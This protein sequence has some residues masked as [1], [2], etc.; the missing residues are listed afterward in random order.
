MLIATAESE[1]AFKDM[2]SLPY[3]A[4]A[5]L[6]GIVSLGRVVKN[7]LRHLRQRVM[8]D[9]QRA[10]CVV[11]VR[12][13]PDLTQDAMQVFLLRRAKNAGFMASFHAF[14]GG[15]IEACDSLFDG[16]GLALPYDLKSDAKSAAMRELFEE[17]DVFFTD[18]LDDKARQRLRQNPDLWPQIANKALASAAKKPEIWPMGRWITPPF[19]PRRFDATYILMRMPKGEIARVATAEHE[20]GY[21]L[22]PKQALQAHADGELLLAYPVLE[23]L[24]ILEHAQGDLAQASALAC[25]RTQNPPTRLGGE[26]AA[27]IHCLPVKTPTLPPATHTNTYILGEDRHVIIDPA[28][29][30]P[31]EQD[32][33][34]AYLEAQKSQ[35]AH[36]QAI[37]LTH[38]HPDHLGAVERVQKL[39]DL[40][41]W[42]HTETA[43]ALAGS[44]KIHRHLR[45]GEV[46]ALGP[47]LNRSQWQ[48]LHT[49]GHAKGHICLWDSGRR[50]MLSGDNVVGF[51]TTLIAEPDGNMEIYLASLNRMAALAPKL[52]LPAHGG[53]IGDGKAAIERLIAHRLRREAKIEA[54]LDPQIWQSLDAISTQAYAELGD[55]LDGPRGNWVR[56][57]TQAHLSRLIA[58][59]RAQHGPQGYQGC[60]PADLQTPKVQA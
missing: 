23:T 5:S 35:G 17:T 42:A 29:P 31:K 26:I 25:A 58:L 59:G 4:H 55:P 24:R 13:D 41:V 6:P 36:F 48:V 33:L 1:T 47:D 51:G 22:S 37:V 14:P 60:N 10:A 18:N 2:G 39:L 7:A 46:L 9:H 38:H 54:C 15:S 28:T 19:L 3:A 43:S 8:K 12:P 40:E 45:D 56:A 16:G 20:K 30:Y 50:F 21:W 53:P 57:S 44:F 34:C 11:L 32:R 27:G 52:V 49:P